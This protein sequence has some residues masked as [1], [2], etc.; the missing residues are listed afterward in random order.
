MDRLGGDAVR[1][2]ERFVVAL[3]GVSAPGYRSLA[4]AYLR[5]ALKADA[6]LPELWITTPEYTTATD[7][8]R[9]SV[10]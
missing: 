2:T 3:C 7:P 8:D 1:D 6:R 9:K 5:A 4:N 10:V